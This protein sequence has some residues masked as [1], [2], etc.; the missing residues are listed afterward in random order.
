MIVRGLGVVAHGS[1]KESRRVMVELFL[2]KLF[3]VHYRLT[4]PRLPL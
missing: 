3:G 2:V 4:T 1:A